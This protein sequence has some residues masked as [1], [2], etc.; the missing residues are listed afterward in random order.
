MAKRNESIRTTVNEAAQT[1]EFS[2]DGTDLAPITFAVSQLTAELCNYAILHGLKAKIGDAAAK[3]RNKETGASATM[4]E[5]RAAMMSVVDTLLAGQWNQRNGEGGSEA[6]LLLS[7]LI[8]FYEGKK[9]EEEARAFYNGLD[10]AQ[11]S[12]L[13]ANPRIA[14][15]IARIKSERAAK[16]ADIDTDALLD[17]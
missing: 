7:A 3:P 2:F 11:R 4:E 14:P 15:I 12:A 16:K 10:D 8:E 5:K 9:T 6:G 17:M 13:R 1:I